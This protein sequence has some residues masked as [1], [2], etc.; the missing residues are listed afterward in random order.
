MKKVTNSQFRGTNTDILGRRYFLVAG[1]F[2]CAVGHLVVG[3]AKNN[4]TIIAGMA[5]IGF[6]AANCQLAA[7]ALPELLPNKWRH[8]GMVSKASTATVSHIDA[9]LGVVIAD[10]FVFV[11]TTIF[12]VTARYGYA[13]H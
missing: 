5:V 4:E 12:P 3:C 13:S 2:I 11:A 9:I 10:A 8:I 7:Y 6:G 1:N